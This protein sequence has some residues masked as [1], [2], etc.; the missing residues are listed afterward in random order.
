MEDHYKQEALRS[1]K[2]RLETEVSVPTGEIPDL[3][4]QLD[5][6]NSRLEEDEEFL[7]L[8]LECFNGI[9]FKGTVDGKTFSLSGDFEKITGYSRKEIAFDA[10]TWTSLI[11][12]ED[13]NSVEDEINQLTY[14]PGVAMKREF[15][16]VR[17]DGELRWVNVFAHSSKSRGLE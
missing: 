6:R 5:S 17:K 13:L 15:R 3:R 7:K 11:H 8:L 2:R 16:I 12:P 10:N 1:E 9:F 4:F 14:V